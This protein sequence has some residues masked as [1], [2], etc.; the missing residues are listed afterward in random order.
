[1]PRPERRKKMRE[2]EQSRVPSRRKLRQGK[3]VG[4]NQGER[5]PVNLDMSA[6]LR[7]LPTIVQEDQQVK[8]VQSA[9]VEAAEGEVEQFEEPMFAG[10]LMGRL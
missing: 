1:M 6:T 3:G 8:D 10:S 4:S 9:E 2:D 7:H 5:A